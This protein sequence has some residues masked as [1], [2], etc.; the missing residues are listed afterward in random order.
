MSLEYDLKLRS[1]K[2]IFLPN[3]ALFS[4][5]KKGYNSNNESSIL[6]LFY[7]Y[8][9]LFICRKENYYMVLQYK[10]FFLGNTKEVKK[11]YL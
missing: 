4:A 2:M 10:R 11:I 3:Q 7:D 5:C 1:Q 6:Q 9:S 8:F